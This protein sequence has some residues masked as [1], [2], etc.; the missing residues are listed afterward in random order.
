MRSRTAACVS[1]LFVLFGCP[2][3]WAQDVTIVANKGVPVFQVSEA[4]LH[5]IFTGAR[6]RFGDGSRAVPVVLK[7]GPVHEVFLRKHVGESL[8][9]FRT[10]WQKLVFTGEGAMLKEFS[11]EALLLEYVAAT[12][13]AIG[14]VSRTPEGST[15]KILQVS[16]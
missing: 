2:R 12:T 11:S 9:E 6:S 5:D 10:R 1:V 16:Q 15:V 4:Q 3:L 8:N 7:G 13:G 14:Y